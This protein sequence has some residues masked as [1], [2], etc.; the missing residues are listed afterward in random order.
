MVTELPRS[1]GGGDSE[2]GEARENEKRGGWGRRGEE[3]E[4]EERE[5][6][7]RYLLLFHCER[8]L[9]QFEVGSGGVEPVWLG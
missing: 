5:R 4:E 6:E 1:Q 2:G 7:N 8:L 9:S 3:K